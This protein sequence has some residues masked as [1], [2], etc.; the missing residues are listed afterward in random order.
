M[1]AVRKNKERDNSN[2]TYNFVINMNQDDYERG[3]GSKHLDQMEN[4]ID[5]R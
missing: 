4:I 5:V 1:P 2:A 3:A